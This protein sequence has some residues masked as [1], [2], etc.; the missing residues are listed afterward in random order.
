M[1]E[2]SVQRQSWGGGPP[3]PLC[4]CKL[5]S[6]MSQLRELLQSIAT[7]AVDCIPQVVPKQSQSCPLL[8]SS[9]VVL[10]QPLIARCVQLWRKGAQDQCGNENAVPPR[11]SS[12]LKMA[13]WSTI[14]AHLNYLHPQLVQLSFGIFT[15]R[16]RTIH[17]SRIRCLVLSAF[18]QGTLILTK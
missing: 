1:M 15:I 13:A 9:Q 16:T 8:S 12:V 10:K 18:R 2:K 11:S 3:P 5:C 7:K 17:S 14:L 6:A 4:N